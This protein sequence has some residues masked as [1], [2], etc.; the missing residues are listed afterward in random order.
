MDSTFASHSLLGYVGR[1]DGFVR[2]GISWTE[3]CP[4][5]R[6]RLHHRDFD[7]KHVSEA[8][9][10]HA[11]LSCS[12]CGWWGF[13]EAGDTC[14]TPHHDYFCGILQTFDL[15]EA[16][17]PIEILELELPR[18][19]ERVG[20][21]H[22]SRLED[23]VR[24]ML[25]AV[26]RCDVRHVGYT[27]DGG[28][29]LLILDG[30]TPVAVQVKR[31]ANPSKPELVQGVREFLGA[32]LLAGYKRLLYVTTAE[33]FS[34]GAV[35]AARR[36]EEMI[37]NRFELVAMK[38]LRRYLPA[39]QNQNPWDFAVRRANDRVCKVP[40]IPNP[41]AVANYAIA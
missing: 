38:E 18:W 28:V 24:S 37:V 29:D 12:V 36:S 34:R 15:R 2:P 31:R 19:I 8:Y 5:C 30:E 4:F 17:T 14:N 41:Y 16:E 32:A 26:W 13:S 22:P 23:V 9:R 40:T 6:A 21:L 39:M 10:R 20:E 3:Q 27:R 33:R 11:V 7:L 25:R 35:E 1:D